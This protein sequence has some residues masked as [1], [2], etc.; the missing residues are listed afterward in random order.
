MSLTVLF[1]K[2]AVLLCD[3]IITGGDLERPQ[4]IQI[5]TNFVPLVWERIMETRF[6]RIDL[7]PRDGDI[8]PS[9][10]NCYVYKPKQY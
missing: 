6:N 4:E 2:H 5:F 10:E 3:R 9:L 1:M 8:R 7:T